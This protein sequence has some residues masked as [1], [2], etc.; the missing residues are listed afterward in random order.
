MTDQW[1]NGITQVIVF[2][3]QKKNIR[4][5]KSPEFRN[6]NLDACAND[7]A[8]HREKNS[9]NFQPVTEPVTSHLDKTSSESSAP[10]PRLPRAQLSMMQKVEFHLQDPF[11]HLKN[12]LPT[13]GPDGHRWTM[14]PTGG[15]ETKVSVCWAMRP[16]PKRALRLRSSPSLRDL[17]GAHM[18]QRPLKDIMIKLKVK[19]QFSHVVTAAGWWLVVSNG[20][21]SCQ[22][23]NGTTVVTSLSES[24]SQSGWEMDHVLNNGPFSW[25]LQ[26]QQQGRPSWIPD[27]GAARMGLRR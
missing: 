26:A 1:S 18:F 14:A 23:Y 4:R 8:F 16:L 25:G 11:P 9:L 24:S 3:P 27:T 12:E 15:L 2:S 19:L 22:E 10:G 6:P 13:N 17:R 5:S 20:F 7:A 21:K